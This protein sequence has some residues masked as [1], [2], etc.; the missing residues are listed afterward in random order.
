MGGAAPFE[1]IGTFL[2]E[3]GNQNGW[4]GG[5]AGGRREGDKMAAS[6]FFFSPLNCEIT[7]W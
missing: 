2:C 4:E 1:L 3:R 5:R 7:W 6:A